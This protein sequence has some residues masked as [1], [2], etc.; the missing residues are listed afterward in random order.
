MF[1]KITRAYDLTTELEPLSFL[2]TAALKSIEDEI[3]TL[4]E[5][6][7]LEVL[8]EEAAL[9]PIFHTWHPEAAMYVLNPGGDLVI[10]ELKQRA[11]AGTMP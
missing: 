2:D 11:D 8:F 9:M 7:L 10:F 3:G 5:T 4:F 6:T 1:Y